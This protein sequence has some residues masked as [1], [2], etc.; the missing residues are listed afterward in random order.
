MTG[1]YITPTAVPSAQIFQAVQGGATGVTEPVWGLA[2]PGQ[3]FSDG[4]VVWACI[5]S[6]QQS[7]LPPVIAVPLDTDANLVAAFN[8]AL[9]TLADYEAVTQ[10]FIA[11]LFSSPHHWTAL[12]TIDLLDA[13]TAAITALTA[14]AA[15]INYLTIVDQ[16]EEVGGMG[17]VGNFGVPPIVANSGS[18]Q[19]TG[20]STPTQLVASHDVPAAPAGGGF[21]RVSVAAITSTATPPECSVDWQDPS[22]GTFT[23]TPQT[24]IETSYAGGTVYAWSFTALVWVKA[25]TTL[26]VYVSGSPTSSTSA[27]FAT[28]EGL[29]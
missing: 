17:T 18:G 21:Y 12:Q 19:A 2:I 16:V 28:I 23:G 1:A 14:P 6:Y 26:N 20:F 22:L 4:S 9:E 11:D 10:L 5:G 8:A 3:Q 27:A 13:G 25:G 24:M 29:S 7:G 15:T